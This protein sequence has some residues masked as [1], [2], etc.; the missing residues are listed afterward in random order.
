MIYG[1]VIAVVNKVCLDYS[2]NIMNA[3]SMKPTGLI[4]AQVLVHITQVFLLNDF[5]AT[6]A[7]VCM[8]VI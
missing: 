7:S 6:A 1:P 3:I 4:V 5:Y 8:F 2:S